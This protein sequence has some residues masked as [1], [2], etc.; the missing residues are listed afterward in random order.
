[1]VLLRVVFRVFPKNEPVCRQVKW[2]ISQHLPGGQQF[3]TFLL[4][5]C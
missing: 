5:F 4:M 3:C 2:I 1:M